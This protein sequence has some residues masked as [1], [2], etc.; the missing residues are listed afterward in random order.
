MHESRHR[1]WQSMT[2]L[3]GDTGPSPEARVLVTTQKVCQSVEL[4]QLTLEGGLSAA[5]LREGPVARRHWPQ[6]PAPF[7]PVLGPRSLRGMQLACSRIFH[8]P[9]ASSLVQGEKKNRE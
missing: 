4:M 7:S 3:V 1:R 2:H 5:Q 9:S 6:R 8:S